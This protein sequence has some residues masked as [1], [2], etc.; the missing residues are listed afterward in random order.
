MNLFPS[1]LFLK[2]KKKNILE[3][4]LQQK[5]KNNKRK[6]TIALKNRDTEP[7]FQWKYVP[8]RQRVVD[9]ND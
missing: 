6:N 2:K 9:L 1:Y 4:L 8:K 5:Q 7:G 3:Y